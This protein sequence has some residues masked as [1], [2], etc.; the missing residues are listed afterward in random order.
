MKRRKG[1]S[2]ITVI[3]FMMFLMIVG[4]TTIT[5]I[6][7]DYKFRLNESERIEN[8]YGAESGLEIS[9]DILLKSS[10]YAVNEAIRVTSEQVEIDK[11]KPLSERVDLNQLFK[12][13]YV[14]AL[15][16]KNYHHSLASSQTLTDGLA[17]HLLKSL[18]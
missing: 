8:F 2:L 17:V 6:T 4:A 13:T 18:K 12:K 16:D 3:I 10:D 1:S 11:N 5:M 7:M 9:Y 14:Q 15:F